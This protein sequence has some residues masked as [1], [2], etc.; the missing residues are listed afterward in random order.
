MSRKAASAVTPS[1]LLLL[2][3]L[4]LVLVFWMMGTGTRRSSSEPG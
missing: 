3:V 2:L 4:T 1:R